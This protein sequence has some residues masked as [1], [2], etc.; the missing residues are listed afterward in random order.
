[1]EKQLIISIGREF[2]S[3]GHEIAEIIAKDL[4]L[5]LYD[6]SL[7]DNIAKEKGFSLEDLQKYDEKRKRA[8]VSRS[9]RGYSNSIPEAVAQVQ[10]DYIREKAASGESFVVVG[11]CSDIVLKDYPGLFSVFILADKESKMKHVMGKFHLSEEEAL[12]KMKRHDTTRK[13]YH[14]SYSKIS[15]GDS[16]G[17]DLCINS[18]RLGIDDTVEVIEFYARKK[19]AK[20][21][22]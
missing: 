7:L 21:Q 4:N 11:R 16:R 10:F 18:S 6:R 9:V 14:N 22:A 1:M 12:S 17:Y 8:F 20:L 15:W 2:G 13:A 5:P 19:A 3:C